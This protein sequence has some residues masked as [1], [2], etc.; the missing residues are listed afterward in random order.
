MLLSTRFPSY[1]MNYE[2]HF[3]A[4]N[5]VLLLTRGYTVYSPDSCNGPV[6]P[7]ANAKA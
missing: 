6:I 5:S 2:K 1:F 3:L 4:V 7:P